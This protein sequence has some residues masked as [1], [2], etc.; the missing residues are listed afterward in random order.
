MA[1]ESHGRRHCCCR[2]TGALQRNQGLACTPPAARRAECHDHPAGRRAGPWWT[3][4]A[5]FALEFTPSHGEELQTEYLVSREHALDAIEAIRA[6]EPVI[7]PHL[8]ISEIRIMTAD[9]LWL[10]PS[11][12]R[13]S[14]G[15]HFA[16]KQ[17]DAVY[18]LLPTI[19]VALV[20]FD[21]RPHWGKVCETD[22]SA[23]PRCIRSS[24]ISVSWLTGSTRQESSATTTRAHDLRRLTP[25]YV[26]PFALLS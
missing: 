9:E 3:R 10:S 4:L 8:L 24:P 26:G 25:H 14:V 13:E 17:E 6:L 16:W 2:A 19:D 15:I 21:A 12:E 7:G 23:S 11:F 5:H 20:P 22:A 18:A 1:E